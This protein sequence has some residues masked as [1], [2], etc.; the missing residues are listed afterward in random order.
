M[1]V[2]Q[3]LHLHKKISSKIV[4]KKILENQHFIQ[5][6]SVIK[7]AEESVELNQTDD[8]KQLHD[9]LN[10]EQLEKNALA[11]KLA[12]TA[13]QESSALAAAQG[14][15][16]AYFSE[17][18][19]QCLQ[20]IVNLQAG[21]ARIKAKVDFTVKYFKNAKE[22]SLLGSNLIFIK[23]IEDSLSVLEQG[24]NT[25]QLTIIKAKHRECEKLVDEL[26][27]RTSKLTHLEKIGVQ[28]VL[29]N[30]QL[31]QTKENRAEKQAHEAAHKMFN[32]KLDAVSLALV[33]DALQSSKQT[34]KLEENTDSI[35]STLSAIVDAVTLQHAKTE[36]E[37]TADVQSCMD[38]LVMH[39]AAEDSRRQVAL[40]EYELA[41]KAS[42]SKGTQKFLSSLTQFAGAFFY[43]STVV[44]D[45][46]SKTL[47]PVVIKS[48][49]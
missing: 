42:I 38:D 23:T 2:I 35:S 48:S 26:A 3:S 13:L 18:K 11:A 27:D 34:L 5:L 29:A 7:N 19:M 32:K 28:K 40:G 22:L 16:K 44:D 15:Y 21:E 24:H 31:K 10:W 45:G 17:F 46:A 25:S 36:T 9:K 47:W 39:T 41:V 1:Q 12:M 33:T 49:I 20:G 14:Q 8:F 43:Q 30:Y 37:L 4:V 6:L